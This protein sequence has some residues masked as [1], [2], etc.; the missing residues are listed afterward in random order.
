MLALVPRRQPGSLSLCASREPQTRL[1]S[2]HCSASAGGWVY[3][4]DMAL[5]KMRERMTAEPGVRGHF[6]PPGFATRSEIWGTFH[7]GTQFLC[8]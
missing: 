8:L 6:S 7:F 3:S 1:A 4:W 5:N 2:W